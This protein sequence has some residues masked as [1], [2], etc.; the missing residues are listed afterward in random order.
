MAIHPGAKLFGRTQRR[1]GLFGH[2]H[3]P[4]LDICLKK[5]HMSIS[6]YRLDR[7]IAYVFGSM[8]VPRP[9]LRQEQRDLT[10]RRIM[11]AAQACFYERGVAH[12]S[13]EQIARHAGVGR[14]TIYLHFPTK[15]PP[16]PALR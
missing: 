4:W 15:H 5:C 8:R 9:S 10:R 3:S 6:S 2:I 11:E 14:A 12:T 1:G 13:V 16:P 7:G